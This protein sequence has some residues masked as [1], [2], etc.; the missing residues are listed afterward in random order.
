MGMAYR[1]WCHSGVERNRIAHRPL[2]KLQIQG[3]ARIATRGARHI[4]TAQPPIPRTRASADVRSVSA[5]DAFG[6]R[7]WSM[8]AS[9][10]PGRP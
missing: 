8:N 5:T 2:H 9:G 7:N 6:P 3:T 1:T 4:S 10:H